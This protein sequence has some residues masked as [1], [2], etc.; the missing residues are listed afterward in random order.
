MERAELQHLYQMGTDRISILVKVTN[1]EFIDSYN[2]AAK[3]LK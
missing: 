2:L 3:A 1:R